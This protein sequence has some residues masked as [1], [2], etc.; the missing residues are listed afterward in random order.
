MPE[1]TTETPATTQ[2]EVETEA[3]AETTPTQEKTEVTIAAPTNAAEAGGYEVPVQ[4]TT[5]AVTEA[6]EATTQVRMNALIVLFRQSNGN[7][8][9]VM[10]FTFEQRY[11][12]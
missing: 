2:A 4:T 1:Q 5:E 7:G 3:P 10:Q 6:P 9:K 12:E 11:I 8:H